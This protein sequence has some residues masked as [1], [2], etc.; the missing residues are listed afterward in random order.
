M[1]VYI[2]KYIGSVLCV[3]GSWL[4]RHSS[5]ATNQCTIKRSNAMT[6]WCC[7]GSLMLLCL[8]LVKQYM[9]PTHSSMLSHNSHKFKRFKGQN[10]ISSFDIK[11]WDRQ[12]SSPSL[13]LYQYLSLESQHRNPRLT[14]F[15]AV[16]QMIIKLWTSS[17]GG[18]ICWPSPWLTLRVVGVAPE[19]N[20]WIL[21]ANAPD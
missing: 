18:T 16:Q 10:I 12:L 19:T 14:D 11:I 7:L 9:A 6:L 2:D 4:A 3:G 5:Q 8:S 20:A 21:Q 15:V 13:R 17:L 1:V